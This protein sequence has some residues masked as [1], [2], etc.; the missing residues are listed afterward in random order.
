MSDYCKPL[1]FIVT[2][3]NNRADRLVEQLR[4]LSTLNRPL[5]ATNCPLISI[6]DYFDLDWHNLESIELSKF[7]GVVFISGNAIE[8]AKIK[9][10]FDNWLK[11]I[12]SPLYTVGRQS[13]DVLRSALNETS[14][15][16]NGSDQTTVLTPIKFPQK[17]NSE[18]LLAMPELTNI[19]GQLW[20][21]VKGL[22]GRETL[23]TGL[24]E[25]GAKVLELNVYQRKLPDLVAQKQI[26]SYNQLTP[27]RPAPFWLIT[28]LQALDNLWRIL[29]QN[30]EN[31]QVIVSSDRIAENA[32][33]KGFKVVAQSLDATDN[34]LLQCVKQFIQEFS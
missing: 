30:P 20:L 16:N 31:C 13:A 18:G 19:G 8:N 14:S 15:E 29:K 5:H 17:M 22:G 26:T 6:A 21:I 27:C 23:K 12:Q 24:Q 10:S 2:R 3:P 25:R 28:S 11:L 4:S 1:H 32:V 33:E 9:L 7:N 34:Q